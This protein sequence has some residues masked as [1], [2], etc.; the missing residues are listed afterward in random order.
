MSKERKIESRT[1]VIREELDNFWFK[2]LNDGEATK[3]GMARAMCRKY[4]DV[5]TNAEKTRKLIVSITTNHTP[6]ENKEHVV[7]L[8]PGF[9]VPSA[10][11]DYSDFILDH[12]GKVGVIS[13]L[14]IPYHILPAV[15]YAVDNMLREGCKVLYING[16]GMDFHQQSSF[17]RDP[18][19][20]SSFPKEKADFHEFLEY[21]TGRFE[22][23]IWKM[24]NHELRWDTY[25]MRRAPEI[26]TDPYFGFA[27]VMGL[28]DFG[29]EL[30]GPSQMAKF[31]DLC[32]LHGHELTKSLASPVS[33]ARS[34]FTKT[35]SNL[36]ISHHHTVSDYSEKD[37]NGNVITCHSMGCL[38]TL[39]PVYNPFAYLKWDWGYVIV[40]VASD[41]SFEVDN[42]KIYL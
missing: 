19:R 33:P 25:L 12:V 21:V 40:D 3:T 30:V 8:K 31:G 23:V 18:R 16:D 41:G 17:D 37:L 27:N 6:I 9:T 2:K 15:N 10:N 42:R 14:H 20:Q 36:L 11:P 13:D 22:R 26:M 32:V 5:F 7:M 28:D 24:G 1:D 34:A 35:K 39:R 38:C 29:V 4:P